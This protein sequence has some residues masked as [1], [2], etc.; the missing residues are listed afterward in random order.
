MWPTTPQAAEV[1]PAYD[2]L[3]DQQ[4]KRAYARKLLVIS[5]PFKAAI[6]VVPDNTPNHTAIVLRIHNAWAADEEIRTLQR[7]IQDEEGE[8]AFLPSKAE[9]ARAVYDMATAE[10]PTAAEDRLKAF[11]LYAEIRGFIEKPGVNINNTHNTQVNNV[12]AYKDHG[13]MA[14]W[15]A[16]AAANQA[17]VVENA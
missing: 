9:L 16:A 12:M 17:R 7:D 10:R 1:I 6:A 11:R 3:E 14:A 13:D 5:D 8:E 15:E 2:P 4:L